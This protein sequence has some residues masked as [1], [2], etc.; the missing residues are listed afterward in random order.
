MMADEHGVIGAW[1][2][3][4]R[5]Y[6]ASDQRLYAEQGKEIACAESQF[7]RFSFATQL[8]IGVPTQIEKGEII[9]NGA[10]RAP[11]LKIKKRDTD[12]I[13]ARLRAHQHEALR[14]RVRKR[15]QEKGI[16]HAEDRSV[17]ADAQRQRQ[18]HEQCEA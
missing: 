1:Q 2:A 16:N 9:K 15:P 8:D 13:A 6:I 11:V 4:F 12:R 5:R 17:G 18:R 14:L 7:E 3:V 10:L